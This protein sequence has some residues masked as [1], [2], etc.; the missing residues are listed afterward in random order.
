MS[1]QQALAAFIPL[2]PFLSPRSLC[3]LE[4]NILLAGVEIWYSSE[5]QL[6]FCSMLNQKGVPALLFA[7]RVEYLKAFPAMHRII[8]SASMF[9]IQ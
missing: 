9:L 7:S 2:R 8:H 3:N 4:Q 1:K 5:D 6:A